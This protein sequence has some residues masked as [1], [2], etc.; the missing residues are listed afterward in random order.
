[1]PHLPEYLDLSAEWVGRLVQLGL[2]WNFLAM[3]WP[4]VFKADAPHMN[5]HL[6]GAPFVVNDEL[7]RLVYGAVCRKYSLYGYVV[8]QTRNRF[9]ASL[10]PYFDFKITFK[11]EIGGRFRKYDYDLA[12][13]CEGETRESFIQ[14]KRDASE[15]GDQLSATEKPKTID[16]PISSKAGPSFTGQCRSSSQVSQF[17]PVSHSGI[18]SANHIEDEDENVAVTPKRRAFD[19]YEAVSFMSTP[20]RKGG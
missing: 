5:F 10:Q 3:R 13:K 2:G 8:S 12:R 4:F 15:P 7:G 19:P 9:P 17:D 6:Y 16:V 14:V 18:S 11:E 20:L 1:M